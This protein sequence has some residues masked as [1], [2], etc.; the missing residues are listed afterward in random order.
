MLVP[1]TLPTCLHLIAQQDSQTSVNA[2]EQSFVDEPS[3][4]IVAWRSDQ[5]TG[6]LR[7]AVGA[8]FGSVYL[9]GT[10]LPG[11]HASKNGPSSQPRTRFPTPM[12]TTHSGLRTTSPPSSPKS[13]PHSRRHSSSPSSLSL[14]QALINNPARSRGVSGVSCE[15]VQASKSFVDSEDE[16]GRLKDLL[17]SSANNKPPRERGIVDTLLTTFEKGVVIE[18]TSPPPPSPF[19]QP[20]TLSS[21][22]PESSKGRDDPK[23]LL[24]A[25]NSPIFTPRSISTPPSPHLPTLNDKPEEESI[26]LIA[27]ILPPRC[28]MAHGVTDLIVPE[29]TDLLVS[30]QESGCAYM[31][32]Q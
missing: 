7:A 13:H 19:L 22:G 31:F 10:P 29:G 21:V 2:T 28:G 26:A 3:S 18:R 11:E 8:K 16:S 20:S 1:F 17:K 24:S 32:M 23:S 6:H 4:R 14:N 15:Q 9:F 30:L 27:H 12:K 5:S 25:T